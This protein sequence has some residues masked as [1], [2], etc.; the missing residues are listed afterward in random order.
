MSTK[1]SVLEKEKSDMSISFHP[2]KVYEGKVQ[3]L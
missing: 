3:F 2:E 1:L